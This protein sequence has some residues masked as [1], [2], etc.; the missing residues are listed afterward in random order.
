MSRARGI[1]AVVPAKGV[2]GAKQRLAGLLGAEDRRQLALAMLED[3]LAAL[4]G[5]H[6]I[7]GVALVTCD[8]V[9]SDLGRS[10]RVR[11]LPQDRDV[12][13]TA[14]VA[15]AA[16]TLRAEGCTGMIVVPGDVP[17]VTARDIRRLLAAHGP[18][19]AV[20]LAPDRDGRGSNGVVCSPPDALPFCFGEDS[21]RRHLERARALGIRP[22]VVRLLGLGLD[23]DRPADLLAF[24]AQPS[25]TRTWGWLRRR[26]LIDASRPALDRTAELP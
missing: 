17:L 3:V 26:R 20:T 8:P 9:A 10:F 16:R 5:V 14:A 24:A 2:S 7:A 4:C 25:E 22:A 1:W 21:F 23:L 19:P 15:H 13:H 6:G 12:G 11:L 18:A